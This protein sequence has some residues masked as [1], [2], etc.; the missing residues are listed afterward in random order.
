[1]IPTAAAWFSLLLAFVLGGLFEQNLRQG[2]IIGFGDPLAFVT[3]PISAAILA[4]AAA[5]V[6]VPAL[7]Q[8]L[9]TGGK[10]ATKS[11]GERN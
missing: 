10:G 6:L 4:I 7:L 2:L 9:G 11:P 1:M 3:S 5:I 8:I